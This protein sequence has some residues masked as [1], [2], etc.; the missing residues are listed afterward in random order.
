M[1]CAISVMAKWF[2]QCQCK[3][4]D[5]SFYQQANGWWAD[6]E[7][8]TI[9]GEYPSWGSFIQL[10][11][12]SLKVQVSLCEELADKASADE[13]TKVARVWNACMRKFREWDEGKGSFDVVKELLAELAALP[14]GSADEWREGLAKYFV[15][16]MLQGV[17][18]PINFDKGPSL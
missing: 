17:S 12:A 10:H 7:S 4:G 14:K 3:P 5:D 16:C 18:L 6:D 15:K 11:D 9:P 8:I 2:G 13:E 1:G